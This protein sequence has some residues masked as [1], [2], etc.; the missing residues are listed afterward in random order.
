M[1]KFLKIS[2]KSLKIRQLTKEQESSSSTHLN[3]GKGLKGGKQRKKNRQRQLTRFERN[4][5]RSNTNKVMMSHLLENKMAEEEEKEDYRNYTRNN[6][7]TTC[8]I[9]ST[10]HQKRVLV[11]QT[12][13]N[14]NQNPRLKTMFLHPSLFLN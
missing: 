13:Q 5:N 4:L 8:S 7:Q 3:C 11:A 14:P 6:H 10:T 1:R 12:L 2:E 9:N